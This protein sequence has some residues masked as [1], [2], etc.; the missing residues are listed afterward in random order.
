MSLFGE[1]TQQEGSEIWARFKKCET[2][3]YY[4]QILYLVTLLT[5]AFT[6]IMRFYLKN[7]LQTWCYKQVEFATV[8]WN[9]DVIIKVYTSKH[10]HN[11]QIEFAS[12]NHNYNVMLNMWKFSLHQQMWFQTECVSVNLCKLTLSIHLQLQL[13]TSHS[14]GGFSSSWN[15]ESRGNDVLV[16]IHPVLHSDCQTL[17]S[18]RS[19]KHWIWSLMR[20]DRKIEWE[21]IWPR[22]SQRAA[23]HHAE[24][25]WLIQT[26]STKHNTNKQQE[27]QLDLDIF[28]SRSNYKL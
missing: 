27:T 2:D 8:N 3:L 20:S 17:G 15:F 28:W 21:F 10:D 18:H 6:V 25:H 12:I 5:L 7:K 24:E 22:V 26:T 16:H 4:N 23:Q 9:D 11:N 13:V 1:L 14:D 19:Q